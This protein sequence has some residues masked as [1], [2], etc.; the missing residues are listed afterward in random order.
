MGRDGWLTWKKM[1]K[2]GGP[3]DPPRAGT[4]RPSALGVPQFGLLFCRTLTRPQGEGSNPSGSAIPPLGGVPGSVVYGHAI[5][6][7]LAD[8]YR[9]DPHRDDGGMCFGDN[10]RS[11]RP[12]LTACLLE[13]RD[14]EDSG[15]ELSTRLHCMYVIVPLPRR[16]PDNEPSR[17]RGEQPVRPC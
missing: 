13:S 7:V 6:D 16:L 1:G 14:R 17:E 10:R 2:G 15:L 12:R 3:S 11:G 4:G 8:A 9:Q 5:S